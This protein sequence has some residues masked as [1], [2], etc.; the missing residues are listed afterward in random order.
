MTTLY[1]TYNYFTSV[2]KPDYIRVKIPENHIVIDTDIPDKDGNKYYADRVFYTGELNKIQL[3][4]YFRLFNPDEDIAEKLKLALNSVYGVFG[5]TVM[6]S[7]K[8]V[9]FNEPATIV[10]WSDDTKTVVKC[11][12]D[13]IFDPEKGLAMAI[14]KKALGT[15]KNRSN[16]YDIFKKYLKEYEHNKKIEQ[17]D[18]KARN[19]KVRITI[20]ED[21]NQVG[22]LMVD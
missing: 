9:I 14:A 13:D 4:E 21:D 3:K 7:I 11:D 18:K 16:Y 22:K 15:N 2:T 8:K 17:S 12:K 10:F 20:S 19:I 5:S 1:E 6:P